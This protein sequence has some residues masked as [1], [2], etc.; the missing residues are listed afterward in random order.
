[1]KIEDA[2]SIMAAR[3]ARKI[4][5]I[6]RVIPRTFPFYVAGGALVRDGTDVD[7]FA[8]E[9]WPRAILDEVEKIGK[10][11]SETRNAES[12]VVEG[13]VFQFCNYP[14]DS[15]VELLR[16]FDFAHCQ[17]GAKVLN[18]TVDVDWSEQYA[19]SR[20]VGSSW[21]TGS[22]YPLSSLTRIAKYHAKGV[23][24]DSAALRAN[25]E[26]LLAI[27]ERGFK[28]YNDFKDQLDAVDLGLV[29]EEMSEVEKSD[30]ARLYTLLE[31]KS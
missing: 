26:V 28:D 24:S 29:P 20:S 11:V 19:L 12:F 27:I 1:M 10:K 3:V 5:P 8:E 30:L 22:K 9:P 13:T 14:H 25:L 6:L 7:L 17:V 31:R 23:L 4:Q 16:S 15:L 18:S 2:K 21:Y